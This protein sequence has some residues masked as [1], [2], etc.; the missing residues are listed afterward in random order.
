MNPYS[1]IKRNSGVVVS[2]VLVILGLVMGITRPASGL[3][4]GE[5]DGT[6]TIEPAK[7]GANIHELEDPPAKAIVASVTPEVVYYHQDATG[8][9]AA[10]TDDG[11]QVIWQVDLRPF[12]QGSPTSTDYPLRFAGQPQETAI[13][14]LYHLGARMYDPLTG[15]FLSPD[16]ILLGSVKREVPQRFNQY[17]YAL[18]NP[19]RFHDASGLAGTEFTAQ[20]ALKKF[21]RFYDAKLGPNPGLNERMAAFLYGPL[22]EP[23][24]PTDVVVTNNE[25]IR[26]RAGQEVDL[27]WGARMAGY[28]VASALYDQRHRLGDVSPAEIA[29]AAK[30]VAGDLYKPAKQFWN[31]V[32][33]VGQQFGADAMT[34]PY[35]PNDPNIRGIELLIDYIAY[36]GD[37]RDY[38]DPNQLPPSQ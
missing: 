3:K 14:G 28:A 34:G 19:Y 7:V 2:L 17:S 22:P 6:N 23:L 15:R 5:H 8:N 30:K 12:G 20:D 29:S 11:G 35:R 21:L 33:W 24:T 31:G 10:M 27:D 4:D 25:P 26:N 38:F 1:F 37:L 36:G 9:L 13:G 18:N 32:D 16:P